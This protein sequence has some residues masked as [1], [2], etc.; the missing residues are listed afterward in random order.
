MDLNFELLLTVV[1]LVS[2]T[3]WLLNRFIYKQEEGA[4]E[5][6]GSLRRCLGWCWC[7]VPL[8]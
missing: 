4:I 8:W 3:F 7:F 6:T 1:F 2:A 5:F